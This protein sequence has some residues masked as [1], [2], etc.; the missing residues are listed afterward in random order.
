MQKLQKFR[1]LQFSP[2][3]KDSSSS[4]CNMCS[5]REVCGQLITLDEQIRILLTHPELN[6][7]VA[8]RSVQWD[9]MM[10]GISQSSRCRITWSMQSDEPMTPTATLGSH[11]WQ[12][13]SPN[14]IQWIDVYLN[15]TKVDTSSCK[16]QG[17]IRTSGRENSQS[18]RWQLW[19]NPKYK[20]TWLLCFSESIRGWG[21]REEWE[22]YLY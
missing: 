16:S 7:H 20:S 19:H 5:K 12:M 6:S 13:I 2:L 9:H 17:Y 22:C 21:F 11:L 8:S 1:V 15:H 4:G 18:S 14:H 10:R 3:R